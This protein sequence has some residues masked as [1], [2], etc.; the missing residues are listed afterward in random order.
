MEWIQ[1]VL[2]KANRN[3]NKKL[4][5]MYYVRENIKLKEN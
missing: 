2:M 5:C 3:Y 4:Y 1:V